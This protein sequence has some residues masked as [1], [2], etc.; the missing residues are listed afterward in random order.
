MFDITYIGIA[1][2][3][4]TTVAFL[5]QV[6]KVLR[7][8]RTEDISLLMYLIFLFGVILWFTYGICLNNTPIIYANAVTIILAAV[9]V[10][11][12]LKYK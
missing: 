8:R 1:A 7:T 10:V 4:C 11:M 9:I 2:A 5:P 12:K 3:T 6:I